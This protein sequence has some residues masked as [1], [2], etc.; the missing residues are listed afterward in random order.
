LW[1]ATK[2]KFYILDF[3]CSRNSQIFHVVIIIFVDGNFRKVDRRIPKIRIHSKRIPEL[4]D[5]RIVVAIDTWERN[6]MFPS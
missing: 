2:E 5:K 1:F 6:S 4:L 3:I